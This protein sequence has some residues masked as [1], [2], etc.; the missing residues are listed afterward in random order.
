MLIVMHH[1]ASQ[2]QIGQVIQA[3]KAMG[4]NAEPI[5]GSLRTAIG[6]LGNQGYVD[7]DAPQPPRGARNHP[8]QQAL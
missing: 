7:C 1:N 2:E 4:L 8:R 3:V 6:V 5:P